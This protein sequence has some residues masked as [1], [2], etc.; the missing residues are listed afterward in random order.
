MGIKLKVLT[1]TFA[2]HLAYTEVI[3]NNRYNIGY[4]ARNTWDMANYSML[5][6]LVNITSATTHYD[7]QN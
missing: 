6:K 1:N 4:T 2:T 3:T 7:R 5:A